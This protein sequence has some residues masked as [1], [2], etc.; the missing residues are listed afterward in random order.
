[1]QELNSGPPKTNPSSGREEDLNPGPPAYKCSALTTRPRSPPYLGQITH[2]RLRAQA[3]DRYTLGNTSLLCPLSHPLHLSISIHIHYTL[4]YTFLLVLTR[5]ICL[6]IL[7]FWVGDHFLYSH[8]LNE[9]FNSIIVRRIHML[10][11]LRILR[12]QRMLQ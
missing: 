8:D 12:V 10:V 1:M 6:L 3:E 5:R 9:W 4:C 7:A 2:F 11:T